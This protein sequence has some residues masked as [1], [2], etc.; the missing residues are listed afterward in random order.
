MHKTRNYSSGLKI[1]TNRCI[2]C[3]KCASLC[4]AKA[5]ELTG[6]RLRIDRGK[7]IRCFC[8]LAVHDHCICDLFNHGVFFLCRILRYDQKIA[9]YESSDITGFYINPVIILIRDHIRDAV[10][11]EYTDDPCIFSRLFTDVYLA[12]YRQRRITFYDCLIDCRSLIIKCLVLF[13][14]NIFKCF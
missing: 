12:V 7:C 2:G 5:I 11:R 8:C 6:N 10:F 9:L 4:P 1:D 14:G 13:C 3:G